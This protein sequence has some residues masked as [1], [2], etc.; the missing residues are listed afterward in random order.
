MDKRISI[1]IAA[2]LLALSLSLCA[3]AAT[4]GGVKKRPSSPT[5]AQFGTE[6]TASPYDSSA[7]QGHGIAGVD[8]PT[9][10]GKST[11]L[12]PA[13]TT[14]LNSTPAV[15]TSSPR[16]PSRPAKVN[17]PRA[18]SSSPMSD[19]AMATSSQDYS[20]SGDAPVQQGGG[21]SPQTSAVTAK[22]PAIEGGGS[23]GAAPVQ[24]VTAA[25]A[26][27]AASTPKA[28]SLSPKQTGAATPDARKVG[29]GV[30]DLSAQPAPG[31]RTFDSASVL[32]ESVQPGVQSENA[33][34]A[35]AHDARR[36]TAGS[37]TTLPP[38]A[39]DHTELALQVIVLAIA[40]ISLLLCLGY[41]GYRG[42]EWWLTRQAAKALNQRQFP[43]PIMRTATESAAADSSA[44]R[45][46]Q[47]LGPDAQTAPPTDPRKSALMT[48]PTP[49]HIEPELPRTDPYEL[50]KRLEKVESDI[51]T[52]SNRTRG[53]SAT[54]PREGV[55]GAPVPAK[56]HTAD[57]DAISRPEID[58]L[59]GR[60]S[61]LEASLRKIESSVEALQHPAPVPTDSLLAEARLSQEKLA[62]F[63]ERMKR[64]EELFNTLQRPMTMP[65]ETAKV[66]KPSL[67]SRMDHDVLRE[68]G[69][70]LARE[71]RSLE[72]GARKDWA[73]A[74]ESWN[75]RWAPLA[76][77]ASAVR[78][79]TTR[80]L[81]LFSS[82]AF[83][84]LM[85]PADLMTP[86][87]RASCDDMKERLTEIERNTAPVAS[88]TDVPKPSLSCATP[89]EFYAVALQKDPAV[90][91]KRVRD[92]F[93]AE[94]KARVAE[95]KGEFRVRVRELLPEVGCAEILRQ[96]DDML[97]GRIPHLIDQLEDVEGK[98]VER[99]KGDSPIRRGCV[100]VINGVVAAAG[101]E[102]IPVR[103]YDYPDLA[104]HDIATSGE[105]VSDR[106]LEGK[107][108]RVLRRGYKRDGMVMRKPLV[109]VGAPELRHADTS[110]SRRA[111]A[112]AGGSL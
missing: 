112:P 55:A 10:R 45:P 26:R 9:A 70:M 95:A 83:A 48:S 31:P 69:E 106:Y 15:P 43:R 21:S 36:T 78:E 38:L 67:A 75:K 8:V 41:A 30:G 98:Q 110:V 77:K 102:E 52:M 65:N 84:D 44:R 42:F 34:S 74:T 22:T 23:V 49:S 86:G 46:S 1:A 28:E 100:E 18:V 107:I 90:K 17:A 63:D 94:L 33:L 92:E 89:E 93:R 14:V 40:G 2:S 54:T 87:L 53:L 16:L 97:N 79:F 82:Q 105:P 20:G 111:E 7:S 104:K 5:V 73:R 50:S 27:G 25:M 6:E 64:L 109:A 57:G 47:G 68:L 61:D 99:G 81:S 37:E 13:D 62:N 4:G 71:T 85:D 39:A 51:I 101:F 12:A 80:I 11:G 24:P 29:K 66:K 91:P 72:A 19:G 96:Y 58:S 32:Q 108:V 60:M 59:R 88:P 35:L 103:I 3:P 76:A 56:G